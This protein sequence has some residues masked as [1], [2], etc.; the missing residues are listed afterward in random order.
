[1]KKSFG[2]KTLFY[3]APGW[4]VGFG[5]IMDVKIDEDV[6]NPILFCP[7]AGKYHSVGG[8]VAK[9]FDNFRL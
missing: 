5:E 3:P 2:A 8:F 1:M 4:C 9:A 6:L 7:D